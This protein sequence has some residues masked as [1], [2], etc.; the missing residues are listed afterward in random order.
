MN[1]SLAR[2]GSF[3]VCMDSVLT[4]RCFLQ[5]FFR[6]VSEKEYFII[7]F[8]RFQKFF[9]V[10]LKLFDLQSASD[11]IVAGIC[12]QSFCFK[13]KS[14][15]FVKFQSQDSSYILCV[16]NPTIPDSGFSTEFE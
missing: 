9:L 13:L 12:F 8:Q 5:F 6:D 4:A 11:L 14:A 7:H 16:K 2:T 10:L 1:G 3:L 15:V